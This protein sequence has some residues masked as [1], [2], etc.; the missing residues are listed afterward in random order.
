MNLKHFLYFTLAFI[1]FLAVC[2]I[3]QKLAYRETKPDSLGRIII[4]PGLLSWLGGIFSVILFLGFGFMSLTAPFRKGEDFIFWIILGIPLTLLM[5]FSAYI[6][7][8]SR[9]RASH[10]YVEYRGLKGWEQFEW[11]NV[12]RV[13]AHSGLGPRLWVEKRRPLYFWPYGYGSSEMRTLFLEHE[14]T[15]QIG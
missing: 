7:L 9:L 5:G 11:D 1:A 6:I 8:W 14:K 12:L 3:Y 13:D 15:Y 2:K 10:E 4:R